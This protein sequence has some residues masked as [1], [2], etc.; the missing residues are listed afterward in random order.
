MP[1][2]RLVEG[3]FLPRPLPSDLA[4]ASRTHREL[5]SAEQALGRLDEAAHRLPD[6]RIL[7]RATQIREVQSSAHLDSEQAGL[8]EV[9]LVDLPGVHPKS[10]MEPVLDAYLK[11]SKLGFEAVSSGAAVDIELLVGISR[12]FAG[13][14]AVM[15]VDDVMRHEPGWLGTSVADAV[16]LTSPVQP[17]MTAALAQW[18]TW[19]VGE[20][21]LPL[22]G[23]LALGHYQLEVLQPFRFGNGNIARLYVG[24]ELCRA[25]VLRGHFLPISVWLD[26]H[27]DRYRTHIRRVVDTGDFEPW[28]VFF[29]E[30]VREASLGQVRLVRSLEATRDDLLRRLARPGSSRNTGAIRAVLAGLLAN[31][32]TNNNQISKRHRMS[33]KAATEITKRLLQE[34]F[35][36]NLDAKTYGKVYVARDYLRLLTLNDPPP[37]Q[38]DSEAFEDLTEFG[39]ESPLGPLSGG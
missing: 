25:G 30:G 11:A 35:V 38:Q 26:R 13:E 10:S 27:Q 6:P 12:A 9:L 19:A 21:T 18:E 31:P 14:Q 29:A 1:E 20:C 5:A 33:V 22:V 37:P 4:L 17:D 23:K 15:A 2:E 7:I 24:L 8:L 39:G 28:L 32:V 3:A 34:G 36:E 16:L